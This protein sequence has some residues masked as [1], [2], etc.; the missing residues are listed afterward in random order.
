MACTPIITIDTYLSYAM[1]MLLIFGLA[2]ELP[3]V[4]VLLNLAGLLTHAR[5]RKWR[6][7]IIF[8]CSPSPRSRRRARTR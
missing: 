3:L 8:A 4:L 7:M 1:A 5:F 6:R 2:F